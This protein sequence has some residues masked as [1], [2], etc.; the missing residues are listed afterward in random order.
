[1]VYR[2]KLVSESSYL[3]ALSYSDGGRGQID[4]CDD[5]DDLHR[6]GVIECQMGQLIGRCSLH[7]LVSFGLEIQGL[8]RSWAVLLHL[9]K[10]KSALLL[11][12]ATS[13]WRLLHQIS[14]QGVEGRPATC[15]LLLAETAAL[16]SLMQAR[17]LEK[18][19]KTE[20]KKRQRSST[21][22][23]LVRCS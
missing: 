8:R 11:H 2:R 1:M 23:T 6:S 10:T 5:C 4:Q 15:N 17:L 20:P 21:N 7:L 3:P 9:L 22:R 13:S 18:E 19:L 14:S 16:T 12:D